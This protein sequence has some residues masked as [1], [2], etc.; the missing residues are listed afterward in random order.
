VS[1]ALESKPI[2]VADVHKDIARRLKNC[3]PWLFRN[4][5]KSIHIWLDALCLPISEGALGIKTPRQGD[6][7]IR[8]KA[9]GQMNPIYRHAQRVV[10]LDREIADLS[11][12]DGLFSILY[13]KPCY[14]K[15]TTCSDCSAKLCRLAAGWLCSAWMS[16]LWTVQEATLSTQLFWDV[17][18]LRSSWPLARGFLSHRVF[19]I[20]IARREIQMRRSERLEDRLKG[21][22]F[23]DCVMRCKISE[24]GTPS[25][26]IQPQEFTEWLSREQSVRAFQFLRAWNLL[27]GRSTT[28]I[29]DVASVMAM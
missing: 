29:R 8:D 2:A 5:K 25:Y 14:R 21:V 17:P 12:K 18:R 19:T 13:C 10:L 26:P 3:F 1:R 23:R 15:Q 28:N 20:M 11:V 9:I 16:R 6:I 27:L 7:K 4:K 22:I 24:L